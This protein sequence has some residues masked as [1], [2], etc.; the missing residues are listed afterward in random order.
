MSYSCGG[1]NGR[2]HA[3]AE[4]A[5][6]IGRGKQ[7]TGERSTH[8]V[9]L[10][11]A[12][13]QRAFGSFE[14][15]NHSARYFI[16][17]DEIFDFRATHRAQHFFAV[18]YTRYIGEKN[19]TIG[20]DEFRSRSRH[21]IGVNV[22]KLAVRAQPQARSNR[23]D[24]CVP[25]RAQKFNVHF[26]KVA[27]VSKAAFAFT[28]LHRLRPKTWRVWS[29]DAHRALAR[30]RNGTGETLIQQSGKDHH[31]SI[32]LFAVGDAQPVYKAAGDSHAFERVRKDFPTAVNYKQ[33]MPAAREFGDLPR[34]CLHR[35]FAL[36]ER[37][38]NFYYQSHS[39]P[40]VSG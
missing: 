32:P 24:P 2:K 9:H 1:M 22:V 18:E 17:P 8:D 26:C 29:A 36:Q 13:G 27:D 31:R 14:V 28:N 40:A 33:L 10:A 19:Q 12:S 37:A 20:L 38:C 25:K 39:N 3:R 35:F 11:D 7:G 6:T 34:D 23:N 15:H 4:A 30:Q 21:V 5:R 16:P